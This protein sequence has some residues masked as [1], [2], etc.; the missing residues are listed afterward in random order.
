MK[1]WTKS[2]VYWDFIYDY[3]L[4]A[5]SALLEKGFKIATPK[6]NIEQ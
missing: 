1:A 4:K 5:Y 6:V 3:R 2:D